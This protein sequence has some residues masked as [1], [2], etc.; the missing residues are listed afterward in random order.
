MPYTRPC[1][2]YPEAALNIQGRQGTND[3]QGTGIDLMTPGNTQTP[4]QFQAAVHFGNK[5]SV[6]H[7]PS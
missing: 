5:G 6:D 4:K 7:N 1:F 3:S 2:P